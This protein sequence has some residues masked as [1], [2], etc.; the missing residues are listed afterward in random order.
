MSKDEVSV[1][2]SI[3]SHLDFLAEGGYILRLFGN[4]KTGIDTTNIP[5]LGGPKI[6]PISKSTTKSPR[7]QSS[8]EI[9]TNTYLGQ[10]RLV[11]R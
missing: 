4:E 3:F 2:Q 9:I 7:E 8:P 1:P 10:S 11:L 6:L 5:T